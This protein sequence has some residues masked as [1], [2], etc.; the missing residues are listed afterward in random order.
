MLLTTLTAGLSMKNWLRKNYTCEKN[1]GMSPA[2]A[3][4]LTG[5]PKTFAIKANIRPHPA[6][7]SSEKCG[8]C[9]AITF[10]LHFVLDPAGTGK[11]RRRGL[12]PVEQLRCTLYG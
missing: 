2:C 9:V 4:N 12:A 11:L 1:L 3:S 5:R 7:T 6:T 8:V 10:I